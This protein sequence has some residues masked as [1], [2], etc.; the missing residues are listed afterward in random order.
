MIAKLLIIL[1]L[2]STMAVV[3]NRLYYQYKKSKEEMPNV[4]LSSTTIEVPIS[5]T[6]IEDKEPVSQ[7]TLEDQE[8]PSLTSHLSY[9]EAETLLGSPAI[10]DNHIILN[11][12]LLAI[13]QSLK[14]F[15]NISLKLVPIPEKINYTLPS[16]LKNTTNSSLNIAKNDI[17]LY[18]SKYEELSEKAN[19]ITELASQ[20]IKKFSKSLDDIKEELTTIESEFEKATKD[21]CLPLILDEITDIPS[22]ED[23]ED[24]ENKAKIRRLDDL[25]QNFKDGVN[26]LGELINSLFEFCKWAFV[27]F[28]ANIEDIVDSA[29]KVTTDVD[30][31]FNSYK[32]I[33]N[34]TNETNLHNNLLLSKE[35]FLSLKSEMQESKKNAEKAYQSFEST[36][37]NSKFDFELF[38]SKYY[39][40]SENLKSISNSIREE[41]LNKR[42]ENNLPPI[43]IPDLSIP[44]IIHDSFILKIEDFYK[45]ITDTQKKIF[46]EMEIMI[47]IID[48]EVKTSLDLLFIMDITGSM[49]SFLD[50]AKNNLI[51]IINRIISECPGIDINIGF[52]GYRDI[53][54]FNFGEYSEIDFTKN[55]TYVKEI[56]DN[57]YAYGGGD[58]PEDIA[59]AFEMALNKTWKNNARI[60]VLVADAPCHG[61]GCHDYYYYYDDYPNGIPGRRNI[62]DLVEELADSNISLYC[63]R[64]TYETEKMFEM[65]E[66]IYKKHENIEFRVENMDYSEQKFADVIVEAA[67]KVYVNQRNTDL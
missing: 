37:N 22:N 36:Y 29:S 42:K 54:E 19:N 23:K 46:T 21:L 10:E 45:Q 9:K 2:I 18:N 67:S 4:P 61:E 30:K 52:I 40:I 53:E 7:T 63:M 62:T 24:K 32:N 66:K 31:A 43:E 12:S 20:S 28:G 38:K 25:I 6:T 35:S 51:N 13:N 5:S 39:S 60:G 65:F 50:S 34:L 47:I 57:V 11:E 27:N 16:F 44:F 41:T 17:E 56:I 49:G 64:I 1:G 48:V 3:V 15:E 58:A 59:G 14:S 8:P 26:E 33:L 55:Y